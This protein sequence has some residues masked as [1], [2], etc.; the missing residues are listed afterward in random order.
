MNML[1]PEAT[2]TCFSYDYKRVL[3]GAQR[4]TDTVVA[5]V[6]GLLCPEATQRFGCNEKQVPCGARSNT[7]HLVV[8]S[9]RN[10]SLESRR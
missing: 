9:T 5:R 2:K 8:M 4:M 10:R 3:S 1:R 6:S 7:D